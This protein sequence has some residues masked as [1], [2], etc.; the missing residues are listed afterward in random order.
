MGAP[1]GLVKM[2]KAFYDQAVRFFRI[3]LHCGT[4]F[5]PGNGIGQGDALSMRWVN[6]TGAVW[7]RVSKNAN[8]DARL[9]V[10]VDDRTIRETEMRKLVVSVE[11][12]ME[13]DNL[14]GQK[15]NID[16]SSIM[17]TTPQLRK[18]AASMRIGGSAMCHTWD[19]R[20]LGSHIKTVRRQ[21]K[22][23]GKR[24]L[25]GAAESAMRISR[26]Y[27]KKRAKRRMLE[28]VAAAKATYGA[29]ITRLPVAAAR[30]TG[31]VFLRTAMGRGRRHAAPELINTLILRGWR[32]DPMMAENYVA[33]TTARRILNRRPDLYER[34][35]RVLARRREGI[36]SE[37]SIP[38]PVIT[39]ARAVQACG[40]TGIGDDLEM[41]LP[42]DRLPLP[43]VGGHDATFRAE[44]RDVICDAEIQKLTRRSRPL[45]PTL[46]ESGDEA[47]GVAET[48]Y[49][50]E[51][52]KI[53]EREEKL[54]EAVVSSRMN[55]ARAM[56][57]KARGLGRAQGSRY[58]GQAKWLMGERGSH[59]WEALYD[60]CENVE[61]Q[62][63]RGGC[64]RW[65]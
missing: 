50:P 59:E 23:L 41:I 61:V 29:A 39:L 20:C 2:M 52:E 7:V 22:G 33:I 46:L 15:L 42:H 48:T 27:V 34:A 62:R 6:C 14:L 3:G 26:T 57:E 37:E 16:K 18:K 25:D 51:G 40:C 5:H 58:A 30:E 65:S 49:V 31:A 8:P 28:V 19:A 54:R 64:S 45:A 21:F 24:R 11:V 12:T 56:M 36:Q 1:T 32:A 44:L 43:L 53:R 55:R 9:S 38:G 17:A 10:Y 4:A 63:C 60:S 13:Y 35:K 47:E